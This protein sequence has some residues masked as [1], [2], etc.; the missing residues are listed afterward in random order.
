MFPVNSELG[1]SAAPTPFLYS[2]PLEVLARFDKQVNTIINLL[3]KSGESGMKA[4]GLDPNVVKKAVPSCYQESLMAF[5]DYTIYDPG[6][7]PEPAIYRKM[8]SKL[9]QLKSCLWLNS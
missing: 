8:V 4:P 9:N 2:L 1:S 3:C 5:M 6:A 7:Y